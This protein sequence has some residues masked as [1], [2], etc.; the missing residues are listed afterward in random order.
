MEEI[1]YCVG[2]GTC[3]EFIC[4][5]YFQTPCQHEC[6]LIRCENY[7]ECR[8][9]HPRHIYNECSLC[10]TCIMLIDDSEDEI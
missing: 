8:N 6:E 7:E 9:E 3:Y 4:G 1:N 2:D 10:P 5:D